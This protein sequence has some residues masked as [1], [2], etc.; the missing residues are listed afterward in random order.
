MAHKLK[1]KFNKFGLVENAAMRT[2][3]IKPE[4][5][6]TTGLVAYV[7]DIRRDSNGHKCRYNR[8]RKA[9]SVIRARH[10]KR[11]DT[12]KIQIP[13]EAIT[14]DGE[15]LKEFESRRSLH[16]AEV[17]RKKREEEEAKEREQLRSLQSKYRGAL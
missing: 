9:F 15:T 11:D 12:I 1:F 17:N 7:L 8:V 3:Q 2:T 6:G 10:G 13:L 4:D 14:D 16:K 5:M